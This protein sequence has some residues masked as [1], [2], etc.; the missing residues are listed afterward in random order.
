[1]E[2]L[3]L[4]VVGVISRLVPHLPNATG[5]GSSAILAGRDLKTAPALIVVFATMLLTDTV[6]GFHPA[7]WAVYV[8]LCLSV[9]IGKTL[10]KSGVVGMG[11]GSVVSST[12]FYLLTN[13]AV[14]ASPV[15]M[16]GKN[17]AGLV[18]CMFAG[19]PFF[20]NAL[21]GDLCYLVF[22]T[23]LLRYLGTVM[24]RD[25]AHASPSVFARMRIW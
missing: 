19:L 5:V 18:S 4:V 12:V 17:A 15:S 16:Y 24:G 6:F 7:M 14:W 10:G 21:V 8:S 9:M 11:V 25:S 13:F 3:S 1:M 23:M 22:T 2:M 20:R